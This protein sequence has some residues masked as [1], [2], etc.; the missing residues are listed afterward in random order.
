MFSFLKKAS[1]LYGHGKIGKVMI[2]VRGPVQSL[3][4]L[5]LHLK[6]VFLGYVF[7]NIESYV[8]NHL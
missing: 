5:I 2:T 4:G 3:H 1:L 8:D 6:D 7:L